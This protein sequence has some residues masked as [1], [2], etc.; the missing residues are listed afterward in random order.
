MPI[1]SFPN[2]KLSPKVSEIIKKEVEKAR[3]DKDTDPMY[4]SHVK[5]IEKILKKRWWQ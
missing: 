4:Q 5:K 1:F 2:R 3:Y